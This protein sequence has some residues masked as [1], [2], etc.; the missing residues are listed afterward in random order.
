MKPQRHLR[1]FKNLLILPILALFIFSSCQDEIVEVTLPNN[2]D[3]I[4]ANTNLS[5][6]LS[7]VSALNGSVDDSVD[8]ASCFTMTLPVTIEVNGTVIVI[9]SVEDYEAFEAVFDALEDT[10]SIQ[11]PITIVFN[12]YTEVVISNQEDLDVLVEVCLNDDDY[13]D[14]IDCIDFQYPIV[15]S[16]YNSNFQVTDTVTIQDD[17]SL[18]H[19]IED[20]E[21]GILASLNFPVT[22]ILSD[23]S[24]IEV[25]N[26]TELEAAIEAADDTCEDEEDDE[27]ECDM[28]TI[29]AN[30]V[31]CVWNVV[32]FT[33]SVDLSVFTFDFNSNG[34]V[35]ISENG[36]YV[37]GNWETSET[38][39]GLMVAFSN[40]SG[41][42]L[43]EVING[44][45][46]IL[47]C[48]DDE[49]ELVN[50]GEFLV[51]DRDCSPGPFA[52]FED[53]DGELIGCDD[54]NDGFGVFD[55]NGTFADC[56]ANGE[57]N[58]YYY[59]TLADAQ[60][61]TNPLISPYNN[62]IVTPFTIYVRVEVYNNPDQYEIYELEL[63]L[64]NCDPTGCSE[65]DLT[66]YL[67]ECEWNIVNFNG[68][69]DLIIYD[70][71]FQINNTVVI[72][73]NGNTI[74][75]TYTVTQDANGVYLE[76]DNVS[77]PNIQA[78][79]GNWHII[80]CDP[81]RLEMTMGANTMVM[82][83][84]CT[85]DGMC[86]INQAEN[87]LLDC[88]WTI[89]SY[90]GDDGFAI[91]NIDFMENINATITSSN[92]SYTMTWMISLDGDIYLDLST[93]SGGNVQVLEGNYILVECTPNQ[94][95]FHDQ[96]NSN[97]ELVLD[98]DCS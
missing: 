34:S 18:H 30:L 62:I 68:S 66:N 49:L 40:I 88:E 90:N 12:D 65:I 47:N 15:F 32:S 61:G 56:N 93:I 71:E 91:F 95:I 48:D 87:N 36:N 67:Q 27:E 54:D 39:E 52:C 77:G 9:T 44:E 38:N 60:A 7:N 26:N 35:L 74:T 24:T 82:E 59:E 13:E 21:G 2:Q 72:T 51:L 73:G 76:F 16:V 78:I 28:E 85:P 41:N 86:N 69:D 55:L 8:N 10:I 96:T 20:L 6:L 43:T 64:E 1:F 50:N 89:S 75:T 19:F 11:F 63:F 94:M 3:T 83:R 29:N 70:L 79:T 23:G 53:F 25:T 17:E 31:E 97:I 84:D 4:N 14:A 42:S 80:D 22:M 98:K 57:Y 5:N 33:G 37:D 92:E 46:L 58:I 81:E 45:W